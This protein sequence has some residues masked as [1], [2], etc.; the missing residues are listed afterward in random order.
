[1]NHVLDLIKHFLTKYLICFQAI[2]H[3]SG[4]HINPAVT[5][6]MLVTGDISLLKAVFYIVVQ[7]IGAVAGSAVLQVKI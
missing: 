6:G 5:C 2:G 7:C 4:G 3:V 1:M